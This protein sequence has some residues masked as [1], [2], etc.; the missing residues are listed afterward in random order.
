ML[1]LK[2][3]TRLHFYMILH[4]CVTIIEMHRCVNKYGVHCCT[5][6]NTIHRYVSVLFF[7]HCGYV[8][9]LSFLYKIS[10]NH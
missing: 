6:M 9:L 8:K 5:Q 4:Q 10:I 1:K 2:L 3:L 7:S